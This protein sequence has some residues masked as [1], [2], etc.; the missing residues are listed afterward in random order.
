MSTQSQLDSINYLM[1]EQVLGKTTVK[2]GIITSDNAASKI[3]QRYDCLIG[4]SEIVPEVPNPNPSLTFEKND[5]VLISFPNGKECQRQIIGYASYS[6][7]EEH[8]YEFSTKKKTRPT[9]STNIYLCCPS[10]EVIKVYSLSGVAGTDITPV[11][12]TINNVIYQSPY[13]YFGSWLAYSFFKI[14]TDGT[15]ETD[16]NSVALYYSAYGLAINPEGTC[17]YQ[18]TATNYIARIDIEAE[19]VNEYWKEITEGT[20]FAGINDIC[21]DSENIYVLGYEE[22]K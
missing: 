7:P 8:I 9:T 20:Y 5:S 15:G 1:K 3:S 4:N 22:E 18:A 11:K 12:H 13:L 19:T 6:I 17:L 2:Q 10:E 21:S 14:K 16:I